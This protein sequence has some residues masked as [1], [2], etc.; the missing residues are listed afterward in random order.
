MLIAK[1]QVIQCFYD[2]IITGLQRVEPR[3]PRGHPHVRGQRQ[4]DPGS[5]RLRRGAAKPG[6]LLQMRP[7]NI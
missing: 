4:E 2:K 3:H 6:M 1:T 5:G 7:G